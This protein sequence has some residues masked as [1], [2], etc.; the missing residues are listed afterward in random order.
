M[1]E[2]EINLEDIFNPQAS[3]DDDEIVITEGEDEVTLELV[4]VGSQ[5][6]EEGEEIPGGAYEHDAN[7]AFYLPDDELE[8]VENY[9]TN[10]FE[11][12]KA[13]L[14]DYYNQI[15]KG[16]KRLGLTIEE[17]N[18]P[19]PG[20]AAATHPIILESAVKA[21]AKIM[22]E[23]FTGKGIVDTYFKGP[24]TMTALET[25]N[26][27]KNHMDYQFLFEMKEYIA[28]TERM[29]FRYALTGNAF[30]KFYYCPIRDRIRSSY[31]T[32]DK[33]ICNM[34]NTTLDDADFTTEISAMKDHELRHLISLGEY[35]DIFQEDLNGGKT[36]KPDYD[37]TMVDDTV[38]MET[39]E[40]LGG[41]DRAASP[42]MEVYELHEHHT[43]LTLPDGYTDGE[44]RP[45]PYIVVIESSSRR[46]LSIRRNW[47]KDD[48]KKLKRNWYAHYRLVPGLGFMGMGYIHLLSNFQYALTQIIRSLLDA[49]QFANLKGG[50]RAKALGR[51]TK[52]NDAPVKMGQWKEID[53]GSR[54]LSEV[55]MPLNYGEP[56]QVLERLITTLSGMAQKFAD[57]TEAVIGDSTNY[58]PV[59]TT[60]AL[61][62][63]SG[64]FMT[65]IQKRFYQ[66]LQQE[67]EIVYDLNYDIMDEEGVTIY[68]K[69]NAITV[70]REDYSGVVGIAPLADPNVSSNAHKIAL[71]QTKLSAAQQQPD[72]HDLKVAY[73]EFYASLGMEKEEIDI[74]LPEKTNEAQPLDPLSDIQALAD[75]KAIKAFPGQDH[76][77]HI[78][79]KKAFL[80]DPMGGSSE[81]AQNIVP[82]VRANIAEHQ[83]LAYVASVQGAAQ[84]NQMQL[85]SEL[86]MALAAEKARE[87]NA[88]MNNVDAMMAND[89]NTMVA[90]AE[91]MNAQTR[92]KEVDNRANERLVKLAQDQLK[93]NLEERKLDLKQSDTIIKVAS[94]LE[95]QKNELNVKMM[96]EG[97][98]GLLSRNKDNGDLR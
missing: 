85:G 45:L 94:E 57:S 74:L 10:R 96:L 73:R 54:P 41:S 60:I 17:L 70:Q 87:A 3:L 16:I 43:Y 37:L 31:I 24:R 86:D 58:G 6:G 29:T 84:A 59:G 49:G 19:F 56:S 25:A 92:R 91:L 34:G 15:N 36:A 44:T 27:V 7:L 71:A 83:L 21:Q 47:K 4:P 20:A 69:D 48:E 76:E 75:G 89:P 14:W 67:F 38:S 42:E 9:C 32:E 90:F 79:F 63:A 98:K 53:T 39:Y 81:V 23:V 35:V 28:E 2:D 50:F 46:V 40:P 97:I 80:E 12:D 62:E 52:D 55:L 68:R 61:L 65:G 5:G 66:G 88:L 30:R 22:G 8:K 93:T 26:R 95:K 78:R 72:I 11:Q 64:K 33:L 82:L 13:S 77:A 1:D 51:F 18:E